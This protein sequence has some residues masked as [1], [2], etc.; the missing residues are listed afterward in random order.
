MD[1]VP[2]SHETMQGIALSLGFTH[3]IV[4]P[5]YGADARGVSVYSKI[6]HKQPIYGDGNC[7][8]RSLSYILFGTAEHHAFL[9]NE[10][11]AHID[12]YFDAYKERIEISRHYRM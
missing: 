4:R 8:F 11:C 12:K 3:P 6:L 10:I 1:F 9:R 5:D 2:I 7:L